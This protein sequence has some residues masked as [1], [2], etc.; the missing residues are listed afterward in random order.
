MKVCIEDQL[1]NTAVLK[2]A[3]AVYGEPL[4][5]L[6]ADAKDFFN[7][8]ML[9]VWCRHH[10]GLFWLSLDAKH[11]LFT[12]IV[13]HS[14]GFGISMASNIAQRFACTVLC[15]SFCALSTTPR[16]PSWMPTCATKHAAQ[17]SGR[18]ERFPPGLGETSS[19]SLRR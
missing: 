12:F 13:E 18:D 2:H 10:V 19:A 4:F 15:T 17:G 16:R 6:T 9:A 11:E 8:L 5:I 7:Q 14:L 1:H 3:S